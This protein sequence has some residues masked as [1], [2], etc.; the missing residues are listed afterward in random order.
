M[1]YIFISINNKLTI[2]ITL[3]SNNPLMELQIYVFYLFMKENGHLILYL[4]SNGV[5]Y[6]DSY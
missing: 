1:C 3:R 4:K 2:F 6:L 5:L